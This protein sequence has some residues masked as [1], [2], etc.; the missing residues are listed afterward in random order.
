[1]MINSLFDS[2]VSINDYF[3]SKTIYC[4]ISLQTT[5]TLS[6]CKFPRAQSLARSRGKRER[7]F[8]FSNSKIDKSNESS[9]GF[10]Y[11]DKSYKDCKEIRYI[12]NSDGNYKEFLYIEKNLV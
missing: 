6:I 9:K 11:I 7:D 3:D 1:M 8:T 4:L 12:D 5:K 2:D 10:K